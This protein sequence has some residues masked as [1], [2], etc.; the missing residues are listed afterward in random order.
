MLAGHAAADLIVD[1][2]RHDGHRESLVEAEAIANQATSNVPV[3]VKGLEG[4]AEAD[5]EV[6]QQVGDRAVLRNR[7]VAWHRW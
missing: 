7:C 4:T 5:L 1:A 2:F 6:A 3:Q